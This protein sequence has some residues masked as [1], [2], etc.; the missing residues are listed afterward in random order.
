MVTVVSRADWGAAEP[1]SPGLRPPHPVRLLILHHE[2]AGAVPPKRPADGK[3]RV[4]AIQTYHLN[5]PTVDYRDIAYTM[6]ADEHALYDGRDWRTAPGAT[7]GHNT[8]SKAVCAT[9]DWHTREPSGVLLDNL[10]HAAVHLWRLGAVDLPAYDGGHRDY[11]ATQCPGDRLYAQIPEINRRAARFAQDEETIVAAPILVKKTGT[12]AIW[13]VVG[14]TRSHLTGAAFSL[15][16][17]EEG[18]KVDTAVK[19]GWVHELP[20]THEVWSYPVLE[21]SGSADVANLTAAVA[22]LRTAYNAHGHGK[23]N[24]PDT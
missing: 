18:N 21:T 7:K 5:H 9:G 19:L 8:G 3:A 20:A 11:V 15:I 10:A 14:R 22:E 16:V 24:K 13:Q 4:K 2:G 6:L 23:T 17:D 12:D 1:T